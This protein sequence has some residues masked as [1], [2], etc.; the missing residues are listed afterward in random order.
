MSV[1][2]AIPPDELQLA[3]LAAAKL[4]RVIQGIMSV[5][6]ASLELP[7]PTGFLDGKEKVVLAFLEVLRCVGVKP[8]HGDTVARLRQP[9]DQL[10]DVAL[11]FQRNFM[12]LADWRSMRPDDARA[13]ANRV[14]ASYSQFCQ[15]LADFCALIE[16]ELDPS[17]STAQGRVLIDAFVDSV[18][19]NATTPSA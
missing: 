7:T 12:A 4:A 19:A 15:L 16:V 3:R 2:S 1:M 6:V 5:G 14:F 17:E 11:E 9:V 18:I 10:A 13:I 8:G